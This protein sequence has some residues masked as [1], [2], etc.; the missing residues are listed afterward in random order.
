[1]RVI[2]KPPA[3]AH[4]P[5]KGCNLEHNDKLFNPVC[6]KCEPVKSYADRIEGSYPENWQSYGETVEHQLRTDE[7]ED[8]RPSNWKIIWGAGTPWKKKQGITI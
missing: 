6:V 7:P 8:Q 2:W 4:S 5:C 3:A 1:M